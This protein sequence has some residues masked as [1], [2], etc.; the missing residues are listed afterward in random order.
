MEEKR[1]LETNI[2]HSQRG[3]SRYGFYHSCCS[4]CLPCHI[5]FSFVISGYVNL[6]GTVM[7]KNTCCPLEYGSYIL[8]AI[9]TCSSMFSSALLSKWCEVCSFFLVAWYFLI[10]AYV[11]PWIYLL[12]S[13][14]FELVGYDMK[15]WIL[16]S[17][18]WLFV[19][20]FRMFGYGELG[21]ANIERSGIVGDHEMKAFTEQEF[22]H[23]ANHK[24]WR[25]W[26]IRLCG[27][28]DFCLFMFFK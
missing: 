19:P 5:S 10:Y 2:L 23:H 14:Q 3:L 8:V 26:R 4:I 22:D 11:W 21:N 6:L 13:H 15:C 20:C 17:V 7:V 25:R 27:A 28:M 1:W 16:Y 12:S 9:I 24:E 18:F